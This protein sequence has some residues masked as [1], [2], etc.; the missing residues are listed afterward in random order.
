MKKIL[1]GTALAA[2]ALAPA[3]GWADC[4]FHNKA[5]MASSKS[6]DR[7]ELAQAAAASKAPAPVVAKAHAAKQVKQ[8]V[9]KSTSPSTADA[10]TVVTK[11]N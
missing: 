2:F 1:I 9:A 5:S 10:S 3:M 6:A 4:D 7:A 8:V 11:N